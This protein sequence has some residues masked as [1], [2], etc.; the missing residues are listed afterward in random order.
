MADE[1]QFDPSSSLEGGKLKG[2][3]VEFPN[4]SSYFPTLGGVN[5]LN[6]PNIDIDRNVVRTHAVNNSIPK[7]NVSAKSVAGANKLYLDNFFQ[8]NQDKNA[9]GKIYSYN[10]GPDGN[11]FY[12]RYAAYG[13]EKF[14]KIGFSPIRDNEANFNARTTR[15]DDFSR[16]MTHS[17]VPLFTSGFVS[18]PKSLA[19]MLQGD[20]IGTDLEDA[21][22][23][24]EAAAIGNST[25]GG[26]MGF[27]NNTLMNFGYTA[28][29][30]SEAIVEEG[31][32]MLL[33]AP[34]GG[35]SV[36]FAT[37]NNLRKGAKALDLMSDG[38]TAVKSTLNSIKNMDSARKFWTAARESK[39]LGKVGNF[40]NPLENTFEAVSGFKKTFK[41][42]EN[43]T[44][45]ALTAKTAGAFYRDVR[46]VNMALAES[47]LEAG[48]VENKIYDRLYKEAYIKND[49]QVPDNKTL[50]DIDRQAKDGS[51]ETMLTNTALIYFSNKITFNNI[52]NPRG[53]L[54]NFIKANTEDIASIAATEGEKN[55]GKYAKVVFDNTSKTFVKQKNNIKNWALSWKKDGVF[56]ATK[57]TIGYFKANFTEGFQ[58]NL[59]EVIA[60]A[61]ERYYVDTFKSPALQTNA[62]SQ[63]V[64]KQGLK[65]ETNYYT[66][67][68]SDQFSGQ[69]AETFASGFFMGTLAGPL[70][71]AIPFLST[72]YNKIFDKEGYA[73]WKKT[74][75]TVADKLVKT[76]ND[77]VFKGLLS[78]VH[79]NV[80]VQDIIAKIRSRASK[81][82][83]KD[84]EVESFIQAVKTMRKHGVTDL[85]KEQLETLK[86]ATDKELADTLKIEEDQADKYRSRIDSSIARINIIEDRFKKGE[87]LFPMPKEIAE[88]PRLN[89]AWQTSIHNMVFF[90][91]SFDDVMKRR[92][93][94][95]EK[96][97]TDPNLK[98]AGYTESSFL[99]DPDAIPNELSLISNE[100]KLEEETT[101]DPKKL[102][103][104]N[105]KLTY[106]TNFKNAHDKFDTFFNRVDYADSFKDYLT[107]Q[108]KREPTAEEIA[109]AMDTELGSLDNESISN[110]YV[111]DLKDAHDEYLK[112]MSKS[113][114]EI[115]FNEHV[116][117]GFNKLI[118]YYKLGHEKTRLAEY[119][120]LL[121]NPEDFI[122][123]VRRNEA[124]MANQESK[125]VLAYEELITSEMGKVR[126]NAFLNKLFDA[127]YLLNEDDTVNYLGKKNIPPSEIYDH[128]NKK[129]YLRGSEKYN[130]IY[131]DYFKARADL[132][133]TSEPNKTGI[134]KKSYEKQLADLDAAMQA[135]IDALPIEMVRVDTEKVIPKGKNK[136]TSIDDVYDQLNN[137]EYVE[138]NYKNAIEPLIYFKDVNGDIREEG[139][140]G[141]GVDLD[142]VTVRFTEANKFKY[143]EVPDQAQVKEIKARYKE[144]K[145]KVQDAYNADK[146]TIDEAAPYEE[147]TSETNLET[148]DLLDFRNMLYEKYADAYLST[149]S[150]EESDELTDNPEL[151]DLKFKEWY[152][153]PENKKYFDA[154]NK[155]QTSKTKK[156]AP[157]TFENSEIDTEDSELSELISYRDSINNSITD[158]EEQ[159]L[160]KEKTDPEYKANIQE[161]RDLK[162]NLKNLNINIEDRKLENF[163]PKIRSS[164]SKIQR[165]LDAQKDIE[166][167]VLLLEDDEV[168]GLKKGQEAYRVKGLMHRRTTNAI[169]Q[170][171]DDDYNYDE[172]SKKAIE[173]AFNSTIGSLGLNNKTIDSF[174]SQLS[175]LVAT[176]SLKG[177]NQLLLD[178]L[179]TEL[180][181]LDGKSAEQIKLEKEQ[182]KIFDKIEKLNIELEKAEEDGNNARVEN[183]ASQRA[184][185]YPILAEL[186]AQLKGKTPTTDTKADIER[187]RQEELKA[188]NVENVDEYID[189]E[190]AKNISKQIAALRQSDGTILPKDM[191]EFKRLVQEGRDNM[192]NVSQYSEKDV[193]T[194]REIDDKY[195]TE[196]AA[197][198]G[199]AAVPV[200]ETIDPN[201]T[202]DIIMHLIS[203]KSFEDGRIAGNFVDDAKDYLE[204]GKKPARD[205]KIIS[206]E[207]YDELFD[208]STGYLTQIKREVDLGNMYLIGRN[209]VVY[210]TDARIAGE[211]DLLVATEEGIMI[212]DIKTGTASK[213]IN[214]NKIK[215]SSKDTVYSKR[216]EYTM[217]QGAYATMLEK[218]IDA[219]V[220]GI[221]LLPITR[222]SDVDTNQITSAK[223]PTSESVFEGLEYKKD[224]KGNYVR[225]TINNK[226]GKLEFKSTNNVVSKYFIPLYREPIQDKLDILFPQG[227]TR[228]IPGLDEK[229]QK[230]IELYS[231]ALDNITEENTAKNISALDLIEKKVNEIAKKYNIEVPVELQDVIDAKRAAVNKVVGSDVISNI[232]NNYTNLTKNSSV[233]IKELS[234]KL[235]NIRTKI[236][237]DNI[238]LADDSD[239][240]NE[241]LELDPAFKS[242][243]D[244]HEAY[245]VGKTNAPTEGQLLATETLNLSGIL[246]NDEYEPVTALDYNREQVSELIHEAVKRIQYLIV[247]SESEKEANELSAYQ[248]DI[249]KLQ[250]MAKETKSTEE[251]LDTLLAVKDN[252][253]NGDVNTAYNK[254]DVAIL[255]IEN[256]L[257]KDYTKATE[258]TI[259]NNRLKALEEF[260]AAMTKVNPFIEEVFNASEREEGEIDNDFDLEGEGSEIKLAVDDV[261][262]AKN[263]NFAPY[264][265]EKINANGTVT[266]IDENNKKKTLRLET[267][268]NEYSTEQEVMSETITEETYK[269]TSAETKIIKE[270]VDNIADFI[271]TTELKDKEQ[272]EAIKKTPAQIRKELLE[273]AKNCI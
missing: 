192:P 209:L 5:N 178:E 66:E 150:D 167:G 163:S 204:S 133:A 250:S 55:F 252:L 218:M 233:K 138:L 222:E 267:I 196:L 208:E 35:A 75:N 183:L 251:F 219:P 47:R 17:F 134:V 97:L 77:G 143:D 223:R 263:D 43:I 61:N 6:R 118:D 162:T 7:N 16:M 104:L 225:N 210:D 256:L 98:K 51:L 56:K 269:P 83:G 200:T 37:A 80:G 235:G 174:M 156:S 185:L 8:A 186:D 212:I 248:K 74:K 119:V 239:F 122:D 261:I 41:A 264:T 114:G 28:G 226:P 164:I 126:D 175:A 82:E 67:A 26:L 127:G 1:T 213:W 96:Y 13:Q 265:I 115:I 121:H 140:E 198:E 159:N 172:K 136:T 190:K 181:S 46:N 109:S 89:A 93:Q 179:E 63:A 23:Y 84:A 211:I 157:V 24:E 268:N 139:P 128:I 240:V 155:K 201:T 249:W 54:R 57:S 132:K 165:L 59:Q 254:L 39:A 245:F 3:S 243:Y 195:D 25:K 260:K 102:K 27:A 220:V 95:K 112:A 10:A 34:T 86:T 241:Q 69:G 232:I 247:N 246:T 145:D 68:L 161:I 171:L 100:I 44:D 187:R 216:E 230:Q 94:I 29:I 207:A 48:M 49:N 4:P 158:L 124:W 142:T 38:Y 19:R 45:L 30:I 42:G 182:Q 116:D 193:R 152:S 244:T 21:R 191:A 189:A 229:V 137:E 111:A 50:A 217:Q 135:E 64:I 253:D 79:S 12:K 170:V 180:K 65:P 154:Y 272:L 255:K 52:T 259:L 149:L 144:L 231:K 166:P 117:E 108:L 81:K 203:E 214:F 33:A 160:G 101:N 257:S 113:K 9:Y 176:D 131:R 31:A 123:A 76:L 228:F 130:E 105:D 129:V 92:V 2:P 18:G 258:K 14:D 188:N 221:M 88:N 169:Q 234:K 106:L 168:T 58:E 99:F 110:K 53:G 197:L 151:D 15:W 107:K 236:S 91:E 173:I 153:L 85:F 227:E 224:A 237:F 206:Q 22:Q 78:D 103:V 60:Q 70:N 40:L 270:S 148:P 273:N 32:G 205:E 202:F 194:R 184:A 141:E 238:D 266:L 120:N 215:R 177:I 36:F 146:K 20:F 71:S 11:A 199:T 73:K 271:K 242:R 90:N 72:G 62:Y 125:K 147:V 87:K 262:Y